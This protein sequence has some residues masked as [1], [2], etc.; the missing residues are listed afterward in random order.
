[1]NKKKIAILG[2]SGHGKVIAEI[3]ELNNFLV[4]FYDDAYPKKKSIEHW[5]IYGSTQDLLCRKEEYSCAAVGIGDN[6]IRADKISLLL[7]NGLDLPA[8]VHPSAIVSK[9]ST[10]SVAT[11]IFA[12]AIINSFSQIGIGVIINS[13]AVVEHDCYVGNYVHISPSASLAGGCCIFDYAWLGIGSSVKQGSNLG[14]S[15]I[16]GAG[17]VVVKDIQAGVTAYGNPAKVIK[18]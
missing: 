3:A 7:K 14:K 2:A 11:V 1:M 9:Y 18:G 13:N 16:V 6:F 10:F 17:S 5:A 15:S 4:E 12:G 8:L